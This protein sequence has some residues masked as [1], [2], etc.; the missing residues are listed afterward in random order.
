MTINEMRLDIARR[1]KKGI[2]FILASVIL[3]VGILVIW[4][5]LQYHARWL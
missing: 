2:S 5:M 3:W 1:N 4:L